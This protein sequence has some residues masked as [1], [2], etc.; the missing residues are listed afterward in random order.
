M[1][2]PT[3]SDDVAPALWPHAPVHS[4]AGAGV[5]MVTAGTMGKEPL[6]AG[7][8]RLRALHLGLLKYAARFGW[9][10]EAWAVFPN[11][12]HFVG[13]SPSAVDDASSLVDFVREFHS[14]SARWLNGVDGVRGRKVWH[15]YWDSRITHEGSYLARLNYVHSNAVKHG[16]VVSATEYPWC[17]AAWFERTATVAQVKTIYA[18][19]TDRIKVLDEY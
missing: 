9:Q 3:V 17:S 8:E 12:Y 15:N 4:L 19:K 10:L 13:R 5:F 14:R 6:F 18:M 7:S 1:E 11:H 2:K 16:L